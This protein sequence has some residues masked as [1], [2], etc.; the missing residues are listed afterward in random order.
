MGKIN[1]QC[2]SDHVQK[3]FVKLSWEPEG[4][5]DL[6]FSLLFR[7]LWDV[8]QLK[9]TMFGSCLCGY[10]NGNSSLLFYYIYYIVTYKT[11]NYYDLFN[12]IFCL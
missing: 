9:L 3:V 5:S 8:K 7:L 12:T 11:C 1:N 6:M 2:N 4:H 10:M